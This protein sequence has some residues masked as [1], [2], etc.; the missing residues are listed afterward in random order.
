M[1]G[2][3]QEQWETEALDVILWAPEETTT[4][5]ERKEQWKAIA[6][7]WHNFV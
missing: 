3:N 6:Y 2:H 1:K 5:R 4:M 7:L